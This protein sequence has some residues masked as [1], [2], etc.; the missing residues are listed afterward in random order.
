MSE[1]N[2]PK[3]KLGRRER[4]SE[5]DKYWKFVQSGWFHSSRIAVY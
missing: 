3:S 2:V 4:Q 1:K 5:V